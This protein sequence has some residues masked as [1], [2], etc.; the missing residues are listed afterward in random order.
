LVEELGSE[1][2]FR[3]RYTWTAIRRGVKAEAQ[4]VTNLLAN[5]EE[6][7]LKMAENSEFVA[8]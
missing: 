1:E 6:L 4:V 3:K 2:E 7:A 8:S 5:A